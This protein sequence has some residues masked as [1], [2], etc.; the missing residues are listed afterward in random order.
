[1]YHPRSGKCIRADDENV[2]QPSDCYSLSKWSYSRDNGPIRLIGTSYCLR[3]T[4]ENMPVIL[5]RDCY[6]ERSMWNMVSKYQLASRG[7]L[8]LHYDPFDSPRILARKCICPSFQDDPHCLDNPQSQWF[9]FILTN[10]KQQ[11][12]YFGYLGFK[13]LHQYLKVLQ[14][15]FGQLGSFVMQVEGHV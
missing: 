3:A 12:V 8:C 2:V 5:S 7:N 15:Y 10:A 1:M 13:Q 4:G 14:R 11:F 6:T 9:S